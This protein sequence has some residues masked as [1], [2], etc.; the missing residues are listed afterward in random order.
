MYFLLEEDKASFRQLSGSDLSLAYWGGA[1]PSRIVQCLCESFQS[2]K[3]EKF[4][5]AMVLL[6]SVIKLQ[7]ENEV[8]LGREFLLS[9][10]ENQRDFLPASRF[11]EY[12]FFPHNPTRDAVL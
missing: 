4:L 6:P 5:F 7:R 1:S 3:L 8:K 12:T 10:V 9:F 11:L 2:V